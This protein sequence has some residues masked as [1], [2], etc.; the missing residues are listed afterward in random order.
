MAFL[1][2][3]KKKEVLHYSIINAFTVTFDEFIACLLNKV[4]IYFTKL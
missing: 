2:G 4:L 3:E 1:H